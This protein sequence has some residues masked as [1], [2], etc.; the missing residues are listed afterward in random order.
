VGYK[1][2]LKPS[3]RII[4]LQAFA[5]VFFQ[6]KNA[7]VEDIL[8]V[9]PHQR[10]HPLTT[11][12]PVLL[13]DS[14]SKTFGRTKAVDRATVGVRKGE[15]LTLLG[16][17]GCG[18]TTI[19]R[20]AIGLERVTEGEIFYQ[21]KL[22]DSAYRK[23]FTPPHKR[24]MGMVFQSHAIWPHMT[25]FENVAYPL[26]VRGISGGALR[27]Q[28]HHALE[29]VGLSDISTRQAT[30]LSGGEQQRIAVARSLVFS[31]DILLLDEPFSNLDTKLREQLRDELRSLQQRLAIS[32]LFVTHDQNEAL[33]LSDTIAV[34]NQGKIEQTGT[35][36]ELYHEPETQFVRDFLGRTVLI[37]GSIAERSSD[38]GIVATVENGIKIKAVLGPNSNLRKGRRC[39]LA[40]RPEVITVKQLSGSSQPE[41]GNYLSGYLRSI[42]FSGEKLEG[43][44]QLRNG[45]K[46]S[47]FL[48]PSKRWTEGQGVGIHLPKKGI[49][50]WPFK[51]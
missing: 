24:N 36:T 22:I 37:V 23:G 31:P 2:H 29:L 14:V 7:F 43:G 9:T 18:K 26:R 42:R 8:N 5:S 47:L 28:V 30:L 44:V 48:D 3:L 16:P 21:S 45:Q 10:Q 1:Q 11:D 19:L 25:V 15:I 41:M 34:M 4:S 50:A 32:V 27:R 12:E 33:W 39:V 49:R 46:I 40:V 38:G 51:P 13:L 20:I 17:S 6:I 35:P